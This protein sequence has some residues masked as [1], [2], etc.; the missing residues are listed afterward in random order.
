[1]TIIGLC[2]RKMQLK[3]NYDLIENGYAVIPFPKYIKDI[4]KSNIL[5]KVAIKTN[6]NL[7]LV[8][9]KAAVFEYFAG[10]DDFFSVNLSHKGS[11]A[12]LLG[13]LGLEVKGSEDFPHLNIGRHVSGWREHKHPNKVNPNSANEAGRKFFDYK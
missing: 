13:F 5:E 11:L 6:S 3:E 2:H 7:N 9:D 12:S 10:R 4:I 1:M 8:K